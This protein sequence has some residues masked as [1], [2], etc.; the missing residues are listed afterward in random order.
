VTSRTPPLSPVLSPAH[1]EL[2]AEHGEERTAAEGEYLFRIG[3]AR[4]PFIAVLEGEAAILDAT[5]NEIAHQ[6]PGGFLGE[7]N[8]LTGQTVFVDGVV[9]KPMRYIAVDRDE[10]R[11]LLFEDAALADMLLSHFIR[12]RDILQ[13]QEG[14]GIEVIGPRSSA[15]T[16][17]LLE[18][19]RRGRIPYVWRDT[20]RGD[21]PEAAAIV[22]ALQPAEL[23]LVR[24]PGGT[25]LRN[26]S[27]GQLWRALGIGLELG[28]REEVDL[29]VIG[30]GPAG[31][32][33]AVYGASEGLA[34][35]VVEG[36]MLGGQAGTSRRIENYLGFPAGISGA[37]LTGRA[38][39]QAR[40]FGARTATP[41]RAL[42]LEP[43]N[44]THRIELDEG[45]E[46]IARAVVL[47]T[48]ADYRR[49]PCKSLEEYEGLSVFY[50]AGPP[51][52]RTCGGNRVGVVG[53]G[54]SAGQAAV[55]LARGGALVTLLHRRADLR[56]T[57]SDYLIG[58]LDRYGVAV[59]DRSEVAE[60][61]GADGQLEA[62]TLK[63]G[64]RLPFSYLFF[65]LGADPC[66][67]WVGD[68]L[69]RD[70]NGFIRTGS[71]AGASGLLETSVPGIYAAGDVRSG[72][73]KRC[74][75]AVGEG[76]AVVG[77]IHRHLA[78]VPA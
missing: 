70:E 40:K 9:T 44:G 26:P 7:L 21:D 61:H 74:A 13:R 66:T 63:D 49:I 60:V 5:G 75:T 11:P 16:R 36:T 34:T 20:E 38:I 10:L 14:I 55:W 54:N 4:Y 65:F 57:M 24:L 71:D 47:A 77:L 76:A 23:P 45:R 31:L 37:E 48:G 29:A 69:A 58:E 46:I 41:Y 17:R 67:D 51:E 53:G 72:S 43:G 52:A 3:D 22:A 28:P 19:A 6:G 27:K 1:L 68:T 59:R 8:L 42:A 50:A 35:L 73:T 15:P 25:E 56:E 33:A 12:R 39:T 32:G 2:L 78:G 64:E 30:G 18:Y 62:V